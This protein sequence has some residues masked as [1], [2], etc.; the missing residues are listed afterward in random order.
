MQQILVLQ[1]DALE[2]LGTIGKALTAAGLTA[3]CVR[4]YEEEPVPP[5]LGTAQGLI[6]LGGPQSVYEQSKYPFLTKELRLIENALRQGKPILGVCLGGQL[7]A[8]ALGASVCPNTRQEIGWHPVTLKE[9]SEAD[10]LWQ[11]MPTDFTGFHWHGDIFTLPT[12]AVGL[13]SSTRTLHQAFR[14]GTQA[15]GLQFHLEVTAAILRDWT[16]AYAKDLQK[17]GLTDKAILPDL[18]LHLPP[19]QCL[20]AEV[21]GR[22]AALAA[23]VE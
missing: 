14:Y 6:I 8:A 12:G 3:H 17:A 15:W 21:F 20:A 4:V 11:G 9:A 23:E 2:P 22:W 5:T 16:V 10:A 13:A 18:A 19:M 7:L 1:H